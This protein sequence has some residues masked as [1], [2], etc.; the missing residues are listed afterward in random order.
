MNQDIKQVK[1]TYKQTHLYYKQFDYINELVDWFNENQQYEFISFSVGK[2]QN[3][4][5]A[6]FKDKEMI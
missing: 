4:F 6:V 2:G 1:K 3:C 5:I